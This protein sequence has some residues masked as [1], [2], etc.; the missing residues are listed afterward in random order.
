MK[1]LTALLLAL[2]IAFLLLFT[3]CKNESGEIEEENT[4]TTIPVTDAKEEELEPGL[5]TLTGDDSGIEY[6]NPVDFESLQFEN[7]E[8]YAFI[9]VPNT[10]IAYPILQSTI[11]DNYYLRRDINGKSDYC[12]SIF[13]QSC[14]SK[15]FDDPVTV[16]YGHNT[17]KGNYFSEL[18][19]FEDKEFFN[20]N[21]TFY[22]FTPGRILVYQILS[23]HTYD[24]RHIMNS[25]D[26]SNP[27]V[28][29]KFCEEILNPTSMQRNVRAGTALYSD[30]NIV[31]LSTCSKPSSR[32]SERFL[33]N[34]VL[35][36][37]VPT[38]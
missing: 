34:G 18:I 32:S 19:S 2:S 22:I 37:D 13:T 17:D 6:S 20:R 25:Y 26:F 31:V 10:N 35:I 28:F 9:M 16:I 27:N 29:A 15:D 7:R 4:F 11:D 38:Q 36:K 21:D 1:K 30:S 24:T 8:A 5:P 23:C 14:N 3:A 33:V 12:G